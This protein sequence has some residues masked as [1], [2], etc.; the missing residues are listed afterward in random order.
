MKALLKIVTLGL[1]ALALITTNSCSREEVDY[2]GPA[3]ISAPENFAVDSFTGTKTTVDFTNETV[4]FNAKFSDKVSWILT[5]E[6]QE[7]GAI[8]EFQ[9]ISS[10]I[11]NLVWNGGHSGAYFFK[12]GEEVNAKLTFFGTLIEPE[13]KL[14]VSKVTDLVTLNNGSLLKAGDFE[15]PDTNKEWYS[16]E[17]IPNVESGRA[18]NAIDYSGNKVPAVQGDYYFFIKGLGDPG[19]AEFVSGAENSGLIRPKISENA[20]E[21]WFNVYVY[22]SGDANMKLDIEM[23]EDD[24]GTIKGYFGKQDDSYVAS[25]VL[26]HKGWK[27][28]SFKYSDLKV[29]ANADF[30]GS[31]NK[32]YEPHR[33]KAVAF[34]LLK[35]SNIS[36]V[37]V[38]FDYPIFTVGGPF[39]PS[40]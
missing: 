24:L 38:Y 21:I 11:D 22:G 13:T 19:Q 25:I 31:G 18:T 23:H 12:E 17:G 1:A 37:E 5:L 2:I 10:S 26:D 35:N 36:P 34:I 30:G 9:G 40:K 16:F 6:G 15:L 39:D 20:D 14:T 7:S 32:I 33:I 8:K 29:S 4:A 27:L 3:V 28:F